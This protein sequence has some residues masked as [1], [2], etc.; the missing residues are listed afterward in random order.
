[1]YHIF[2]QNTITF[3]KIIIPI[4]KNSDTPEEDKEV[5]SATKNS[6]NKDKAIKSYNNQIKKIEKE[7]GQ[8][9]YN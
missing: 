9:K 8:D 6:F 7:Y 4:Y 3:K 1:M 2:S 5:I